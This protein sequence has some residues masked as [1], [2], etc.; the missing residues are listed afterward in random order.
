M[1]KKTK[2]TRFAYILCI[3]ALICTMC[4]CSNPKSSKK[5]VEEPRDYSELTV[6]PTFNGKDGNE[7][8]MWLHSN[9]EYPEACKEG[10]ISGRV[11]ASF[12]IDS[13]ERLKVTLE[14]GIE[15]SFASVYSIIIGVCTGGVSFVSG[16]LIR[17][18]GTGKVTLFSIFITAIG[19]VG[20]S[21]SP[22][23][24]VMMF[25]S[26]LLSFL[27][28][29]IFTP[30][31][32][33]SRTMTAKRIHIVHFIVGMIIRCAYSHLRVWSNATRK[34]IIKATAIAAIDIAVSFH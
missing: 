15:E 33:L 21:V 1:N 22:N 2:W 12:T 11:V 29:D 23:I 30:F 24:Y 26:V 34:L 7:F 28:F 18:F 13:K 17:K 6:K 32:Q 31:N 3:P 27:F 9:I 8:A 4:M 19:L 20:I 10:N 25:F 16:P 5:V 14:Y